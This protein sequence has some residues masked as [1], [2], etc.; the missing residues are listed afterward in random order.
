MEHCIAFGYLVSS[1]KLNIEY[2][3]LRI[4]WIDKQSSKAWVKTI[5]IRRITLNNP[6]S[7]LFS[8]QVVGLWAKCSIWQPNKFMRK[9]VLISVVRILDKYMWRNLVFFQ[10]TGHRPEILLMINLLQTLFKKFNH[11]HL[12]VIFFCKMAVKDL[13]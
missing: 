9:A 4:C 2:V 13:S 6:Q 12:Q 11:L 5:I 3:F 10:V 7:I 8:L 1:S